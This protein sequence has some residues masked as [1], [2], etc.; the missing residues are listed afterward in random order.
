MSEALRHHWP[1]YLI[2]AV[3]LGIFMMS[4]CVFTV[5][6][7]HPASPVTHLIVDPVSR[8][9][10]VGVAM[11][12][13]AV[14]LIYSPWG[15][16]SGAHFNPSVTI[17]FFCLGKIAP[18]DAFFYIVA[19]FTGAVAGVLICAVF[20]RPWISDPQ[21][22]YAITTP[23]EMG[24]TVALASEFVISFLLMISVLVSSNNKKLAA[25]TGVFAGILVATYITIEAPLSGMSMNPARTFGSAL[26]AHVWKDWWVYFTA[27]PV[28]MLAAAAIYTKLRGA[29]R[30]I[31]AKLHHGE[32]KRCIF[33]CGY[34]TDLKPT[35]NNLRDCEFHN[36]LSG[37]LPNRRVRTQSCL[38]HRCRSV[39]KQAFNRN[40]SAQLGNGEREQ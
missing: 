13:T 14:G 4:A 37:R 32:G 28:G 23:G 36:F 15:K 2:E 3:G 27:P 34:R 35:P 20:L 38:E 8:R 19:Q 33:N 9:A 11:G 30:V 25:L 29:H 17:A 7:M 39:S 1:E 24:A 26:P 5:L 10:V 21:V 18:E 22:N 12:L 16:Q 31:C 40:S 6:L